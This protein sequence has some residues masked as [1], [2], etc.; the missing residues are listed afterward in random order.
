[1]ISRR[2]ELQP[3]PDGQCAATCRVSVERTEPSRCSRERK[4]SRV[5]LALLRQP[6]RAPRE[7][8]DVPVRLHGSSRH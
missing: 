7:G 8:V 2:E 4:S 5:A 3:L 6:P 1:M